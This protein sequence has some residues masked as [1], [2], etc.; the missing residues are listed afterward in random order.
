MTEPRR[1][2]DRW[3]RT[4]QPELDS[5]S[6]T[7]LADLQSFETLI[8]QT[9]SAAGLSTDGILVEVDQRL[10]FM[11]T[12]GRALHKLD[13]AQRGNAS[14]IS[15]MIIAGSCGLFDAA[16]NYL[17]DETVNELRKRVVNY[18]LEYFYAVAEPAES[19][20]KE[21]K[22]AED[23]DKLD[24]QKLLVGAREIGLI[25][26]IGFRELDHIRFMRN[27]ASAAHPN[28]SEVDGIQL[29]SWL[30][31]CI[32]YAMT[33]AIDVVAARVKKLLVN[34]KSQT[35]DDVAI[36]DTS[37]FFKNLIQQ[38]AD[39]LA[40]G[41]FGI[42]TKTESTPETLDN[43]RRLWPKLWDHVSEPARHNVG[44]RLAHF[45]A[46]G[47]TDQ[48]ERARQLVDLVDATAYLTPEMREIEVN[49]A[50]DDLRSAHRGW[51]NFYNELPI[52]RRLAALVGQLG[53]VP[54]SLTKKYVL[55]L[56][57]VYLTNGNGVAEAAEPFY[58]ELMIKFDPDQASI[59]VR[60]FT[61]PDIAVKL[62]RALSREHWDVLLV[63]MGGKL[64]SRSERELAEAV[65]AFSGRPSQLVRDAKIKRLLER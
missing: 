39:T 59:A 63:L 64:T 16:L 20:R 40:A 56:V 14:Y 31:V 9:I 60:S 58:L 52:A 5:R 57:D 11:E 23:L 19:R 2:L 22:D 62:Q 33:L 21:L 32:R 13:S 27:Y 50:L 51:N 46:S 6:Q 30:G 48:A 10:A 8:L 12:A 61:E 25:S 36:R 49:E 34:I 47:D 26:D 55:T 4:A 38:Q 15:K 54:A 3:Q 37:A 44:F 1:E 24:D 65:R 28:Q 7:A 42:Y 29:A 41:M 45:I 35:M 53:T 17:W 18:D 43:I